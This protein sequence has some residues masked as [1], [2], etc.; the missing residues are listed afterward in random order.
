MITHPETVLM[1]TPASVIAS[2]SKPIC[3]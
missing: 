1:G 3:G 2:Y